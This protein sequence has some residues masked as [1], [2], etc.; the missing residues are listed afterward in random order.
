MQALRLK[1]GN[2]YLRSDG[3]AGGLPCD[4]KIPNEEDLRQTYVGGS[5]KTA[6]GKTVTQVTAAASV[7][8]EIKITKLFSV[9]YQDLIDLANENLEAQSLTNDLESISLPVEIVGFTSDQNLS[10][11][12]IFSPVK[13]F[14]R[15]EF[16]DDRVF[17]ISLRLIKL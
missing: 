9:V 14:A 13:P 5:F 15:A 12:A 2:I 7:D 10:F 8:F 6:S 16:I 17:D 3:S 1:I 4:L 11:D